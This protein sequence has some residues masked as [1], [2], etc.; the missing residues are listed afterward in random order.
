MTI[1]DINSQDT[2]AVFEDP[3]ALCEWFEQH[4]NY[5]SIWQQA[6][7]DENFL[8]ALEELA[9]NLQ[10]SL[11]AEDEENNYENGYL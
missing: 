8:H 1:G 7:A 5:K 9:S 6:K 2:W 10:L 4:K 11:V 3:L